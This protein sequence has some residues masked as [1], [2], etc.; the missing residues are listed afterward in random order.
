MVNRTVVSYKEQ[1][2]NIL[3]GRGVETGID[4]NVF[5]G[6]QVRSSSCRPERS[7]RIISSSPIQLVYCNLAAVLLTFKPA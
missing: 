5:C 3:R 2:L 1:W 6:L 4:E 7:R